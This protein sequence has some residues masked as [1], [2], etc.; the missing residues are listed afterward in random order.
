MSFP[1]VPT[2]CPLGKLFLYYNTCTQYFVD[3]SVVTSTSSA[4]LSSSAHFLSSFFTIPFFF[5]LQSKTF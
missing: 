3:T 4:L 5:N 1:L 2:R